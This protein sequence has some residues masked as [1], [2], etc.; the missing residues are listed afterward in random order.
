MIQITE[1]I[2]NTIYLLVKQVIKKFREKN[3][4]DFMTSVI[5]INGKFVF[6]YQVSLSDET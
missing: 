6:L 4:I 3:L 2:Q 5:S 1:T